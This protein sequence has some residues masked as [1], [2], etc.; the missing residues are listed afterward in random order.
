[1]LSLR[2]VYPKS[3]S[4]SAPSLQDTLVFLFGVATFW[5]SRAVFGQVL[6]LFGEQDLLIGDIHGGS[7]NLISIAAVVA[8]A[9]LVTWLDSRGALTR[10]RL[11][12]LVGAVA[13][14]L[15]GA[16]VLLGLAGG[17]LL[18]EGVALAATA[19]LFVLLCYGW[20][21]VALGFDRR[22][23]GLLLVLSMPLGTLVS[24]GL[25]TAPLPW[26]MTAAASEVLPPLASA[27]LL[28]LARSSS[29]PVPGSGP[30]AVHPSKTPW[31]KN[32]AVVCLVLIVAYLLCTSVLRTAYT[33]TLPQSESLYKSSAAKV[34]L[35]GIELLMIVAALVL[36]RRK[37]ADTVSWPLFIAVCL[38]ALYVAVALFNVNPDLCLDVIYASRQYAMSLVYV[39]T[40]WVAWTLG[41]PAPRLATLVYPAYV[42]T[43]WL[44][45]YG[46]S[47]AFSSVAGQ[48]DLWL[49][50]VTA[51][52]LVVVTL[53]TGAYLY[54][55][56]G[57][58]ARQRVETPEGAG[59]SRRQACV[60]IAAERGLTER[61]RD[62][63]E[64][65]SQ[66]HGQKKVAAD[67]GISEHTVHSYAKNLY[68][69]LDVHN[70]QECIDYVEEFMAGR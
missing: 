43:N 70:R 50:P 5:P 60:R 41:T 61:E 18:V 52:T 46:A 22:V 44:L 24:F 65:L 4:D 36:Y 51:V 17:P 25:Q 20:A 23:L 59:D 56:L 28:C 11:R 29:M 13:A 45:T 68:A 12:C 27:G 6:M 62:V 55:R 47:A 53:L 14:V 9:T 15:L 57:G 66:G 10:G 63:L 16:I 19:C 58:L 33:F 3:A 64:L 34:L 42:V 67:L 39:A 1:M 7:H 26:G 48:A 31:F 21:R 2:S 35:L 69:K 40:L 38:V 54:L 30:D 32:P 8:C 49:L 37:K